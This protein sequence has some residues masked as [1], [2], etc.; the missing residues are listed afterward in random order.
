MISYSSYTIKIYN[1]NDKPYYI[2]GPIFVSNLFNIPLAIVIIVFRWDSLEDKKN[3]V[4]QQ[5]K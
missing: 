2:E 4:N 5:I 3:K 1:R